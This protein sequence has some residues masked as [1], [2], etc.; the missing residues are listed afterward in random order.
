MNEYQQAAL[1]SRD[2]ARADMDRARD[3]LASAIRVLAKADN[4]LQKAV[5]ADKKSWYTTPGIRR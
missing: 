5:E 3:R 4:E 1:I 2:N